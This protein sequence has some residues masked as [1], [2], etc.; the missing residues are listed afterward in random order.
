M[1]Y[2][3]LF[4]TPI[5]PLLMRPHI[6]KQ[7]PEIRRNIRQGFLEVLPQL[8]SAFHSENQIAL[9]LQN[10]LEI[11]AFFCLTAPGNGFLPA[12]AI[13]TLVA[14]QDGSFR[15]SAS[16]PFI[17]LRDPAERWASFKLTGSLLFRI[18]FFRISQTSLVL[19]WLPWCLWFFFV[20]WIFFF[21]I[22]VKVS[23]FCYSVLRATA[24]QTRPVL[25]CW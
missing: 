22:Q 12:V 14:V 23:A 6:L 20:S 17:S 13:I 7:K 10:S 25:C 16:P 3:L 24:V 1:N 19:R 11:D 8:A 2:Y 21:Q 4:L 5:L 18:F 9:Q 15:S